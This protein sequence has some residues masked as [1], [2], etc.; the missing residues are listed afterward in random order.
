MSV[1][2]LFLVFAAGVWCGMGLMCLL[3]IS[4]DEEGE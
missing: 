3:D 1:V 2:W 4:K